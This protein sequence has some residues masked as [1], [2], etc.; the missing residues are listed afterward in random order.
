MDLL[1]KKGIISLHSKG[2]SSNHRGLGSSASIDSRT[3]FKQ[4][5]KPVRATYIHNMDS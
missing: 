2:F 3:N 1:P 5:Y 4:K